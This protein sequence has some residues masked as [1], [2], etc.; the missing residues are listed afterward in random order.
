[1][2][3]KIDR[4]NFLKIMGLGGAGTALGGCD[5]PSTVT[6]EEGK[7]EVVSY[8]MP[9]EYVIP[10]VGVW[11][12]STCTQCAAGCGIH[13]RVREG[14]VLKLEGNPG[15]SMNSGNICMMGQAGVQGHYNPDRIKTPMMR[16]GGNLVAVSW[17]K[18]MNAIQE[19]LSAA[20]GDQVAWFTGTLSGHQ[21]ALVNN[22][23]EAVGSKKHYIHEPINTS[24]WQAVNRDM[25]GEAMPRLRIDKAQMVLSF[26]ADFLGTWI[27]PVHFAGEY[28]KFRKQS[29][30]GLLVTIEPKMSLTGANSDL[31]IPAKPG[32]E[33]VVAL[34]IANLLVKNHGKDMSPL[35]ESVQALINKYDAGTAA[36]AAG[37][38]EKR[39]QRIA[40]L[41]VERSPSLV[42]AGAPVE[43]QAKGYAAV[44]A[45]M[46]LNQL[47]GN[48]GQTI[49]SQGDFPF[50]QLKAK[51]GGTGD[52]F[53]FVEAAKNKN[54]AAVFFY[55]T[56]PKFTAPTAI[57][58]DSAL[59]DV[60]FKVAISQFMDETTMAADVV[61]PA[62]SYLEDWGTHVAAYQPEQSAIGVQQPLMERL[63]AETKGFGDIILDLLKV[64]KKDVYSAFADYYAYLKNAHAAM[65]ADLKEAGMSDNDAWNA[66]LQKGLIKV[67][68]ANKSLSVNPVAFADPAP[69]D[70][71]GNF[72]YHFVPSA[73]L[74]LWD[75]RHANLPW[76][77]EAPDQISKLV[78][79]SWAEIHPATAQKLGIK[80]GSIINVESEHGTAKVQAV[81]IKAIHPDVIAIPM[82]QGHEE[83][84][85]Y[86][87]GRGANPLKLLNPVKEEA[88][89]ELAMYATRV[90][91]SPT[92]QKEV[93]VRLG[94]SDTQAGRRF[95][96]TVP[97]EQYQRT[98]GA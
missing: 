97:V 47:L 61:L 45:V 18:A 16:E 87:K 32:T 23:L 68:G 66:A 6:L 60:P 30:R 76:L 12:A 36:K 39:L 64:A 57:G 92:G 91:A 70:S 88:T 3:G 42:L 11:Y 35:P 21:A 38:D 71:G 54:L 56:N 26:G 5:L 14:R 43:G 55:G 84:G 63:Y 50:S 9:E 80:H 81:L 13:G 17:D 62:A 22:H 52:L 49:E 29:R 37:I 4:R 73:R 10:G 27:S 78:W 83:Y 59:N 95:V 74:G 20:S 15:S 67:A 98:E 28:A 53:A 2:S 93:V 1:M 24:V 82:G 44:A 86:A 31:W 25:L 7:E 40:E 75:G 58:M 77:Q 65:P 94:A 51:T 8:L 34:G 96:V 69:A 89:G 85:R 79:D 46:M 72:A 90:N 19:K 33:G 48:I 41:L